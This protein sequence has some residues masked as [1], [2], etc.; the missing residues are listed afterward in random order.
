MVQVMGDW[1]VIGQ[2]NEDGV[3]VGKFV[4]KLP[5]SPTGSAKLVSGVSFWPMQVW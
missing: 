4:E 3:L 2:A 1:L 5:T